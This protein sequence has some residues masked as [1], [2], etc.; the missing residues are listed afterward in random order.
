MDE[1]GLP[2]GFMEQLGSGVGANLIT[3]FAIGLL[4]LIRNCSKRKFKHSA[5]KTLC[6]TLELDED[7]ESSQQPEHEIK[8]PQLKSKGTPHVKVRHANKN[9]IV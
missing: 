3:V 1:L 8:S 5:C 7:S 4:L 9:E 6:C 2:P